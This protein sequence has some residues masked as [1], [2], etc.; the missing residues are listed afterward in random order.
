MT[1]IAITIFPLN[2]NCSDF[3]YGYVCYILRYTNKSVFLIIKNGCQFV[4]N[5]TWT[6]YICK[7]ELQI[8]HKRLQI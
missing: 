8:I 2:Y 6:S 1:M 3:I 5:I 7:E 4:D